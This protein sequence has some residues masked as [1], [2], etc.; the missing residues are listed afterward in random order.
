MTSAQPA[1]MN[2]SVIITKIVLLLLVQNGTI[3]V[4]IDCG[5]G[6]TVKCRMNLK[7]SLPGCLW[8]R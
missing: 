5:W 3:E 8:N 6:S 7:E 2:G 1:I 4:L